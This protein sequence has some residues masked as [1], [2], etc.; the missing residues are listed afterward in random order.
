[1][2]PWQMSN[3]LWVRC[4]TPLWCKIVYHMCSRLRVVWTLTCLNYG[5]KLNRLCI[6]IFD[7]TFMIIYLIEMVYTIS[8]C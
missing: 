7:I 8:N 5:T 6:F 4:A 1:M 3:G 2:S